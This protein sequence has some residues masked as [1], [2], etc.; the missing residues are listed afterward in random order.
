MANCSKR[1][2]RNGADLQRSALEKIAGKTSE[3]RKYEGKLRIACFNAALAAICCARV[4]NRA[5]GELSVLFILAGKS[6]S[7][8]FTAYSHA[9]CPV[10]ASGLETRNPFKKRQEKNDFY[11]LGREKIFLTK[12]K[13]RAC[14]RENKISFSPADLPRRFA[15]VN[16]LRRRRNDLYFFLLPS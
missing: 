16:W 2:A 11:F 14:P 6:L 7:E 5:L 8:M 15:I 12:K 4:V 1:P 9:H 10:L 13:K 3:T